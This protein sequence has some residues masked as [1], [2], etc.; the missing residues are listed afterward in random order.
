LLLL[1]AFAAS[2]LNS[3]I[4]SNHSTWYAVDIG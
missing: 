3:F 2:A 4:A 1:R